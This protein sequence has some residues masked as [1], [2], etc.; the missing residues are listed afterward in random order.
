MNYPVRIL[1]LSLV[2]LSFFA[3]GNEG[4]NTRQ[5]TSAPGAGPKRFELLDPS[6]TG[7]TF[8][9]IVKEQSNVNY[10]T[11]NYLYI[12]GGIGVADFNQDGLTDLYFVAVTGE[13]K[14]YLNQGGFKFEDV[15]SKAGVGL[16]L[17]V[18]TGVTIVDINSD[19][20]PDIFQC[21]TGQTAAER[22]NKLFVNQRDGTFLEQA[23][24]YGLNTAYPST[25]ANFFDYDL[26]GDLDLYLINRP[27]DFS[28]NSNI[29]VKE[30]DGVVTRRNAPEDPLETDRLFR[31]EGNHFMDVSSQA[32]INNRAFSLSVNIMDFNDDGWPDVYVANDYVEPDHI[33]INQKNGKFVDE[34]NRYFRHLP[35]FSM[36]ADIADLNNDGLLDIVTLDMLPADNYRHKQN[37]TVMKYDRYTSLVG[38]NYGHQIMR[39]MMQINNGNGSF[40]EV[41]CLA[42]I[43]ATDWSWAPMIADL[44]NDGWKDIFITNGMKKDVN[45]RDFANYTL[46]SLEKA[47]VEVDDFSKLVH[48]I[49]SQKLSNYL[50]RNNGQL[51]MQDVTEAWGLDQP[52]FSNGAACVDLDNDGDLDIVVHNTDDVSFIYQNKTNE[53]SGGNYL[54]VNVKGQGS[55]T[56]GAGTK[57]RL[58]A[59]GQ[60]QVLEKQANRGFLS[61]MVQPLH[62]GIGDATKVERLEVIWPD[63]KMLS[64]ENVPANQQLEVEYS[65]AT[66]TWTKEKQGPAPC[67]NV[68]TQSGLNYLSLENAFEDFERERLIPRKYSNRGPAVATADVNGDGLEDVFM[69]GS[70]S[71]KGKFFLQQTS[72]TFK[73]LTQPAFEQEGLR[74]DVD[75]I[76]FDA[77][78]DGAPDLYVV[79]GGTQAPTGKGFYIDRL[80]INNREGL[81]LQHLDGLPLTDES[82]SCIAA[83]DIDR[84]GDLDLAVGGN[85]KPGEFPR[86]AYS[87]LLRNDKGRFSDVTAEWSPE[88]A[89]LGI[90]N[91]IEF[92]DLNGDSK[93]EMVVA[94]EWMG[95]KVFDIAQNKLTDVSDKF[96]LDNT[97]GWWHCLRVADF[98]GDGH[99]DIVVGNLGLNCRLTASPEQ[100]LEI[101]ATDID[102]NGQLDPILTYFN[103]GN[104]HP[105]VHRD[106]LIAQVP[107]LKKIFNRYSP[108]SKAGLDDILTEDQRKQAIHLKAG[109]LANS[110]FWG[111]ASGIFTRQD[112]PDL[113]Q[114]APIMDMAL[115]DLNGDG[116]FDIVA[117]GNDFGLEIESGRLDA[118]DGWVIFGSKDGKLEVV[119]NRLTGFWASNEG[120]KVRTLQHGATG[121]TFIV[122]GNNSNL[123]EV[124]EWQRQLQ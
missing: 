42:G 84:D 48:L 122:V 99:K 28:T 51:Q 17:G 41:A 40:N 33:Y 23:S 63:G 61:S 39:N 18:K 71:Q 108:Y 19:G 22:G 50:F 70:F 43:S 34:W 100:P 46:D 95:I 2:T 105:V 113:A 111:S 64:V 72:G 3:C 1:L 115:Q 104:R 92:A 47:G 119:P 36:G 85:V 25:E 31:N 27:E 24:A 6:Q 90:V 13:N 89:N 35:H 32:G 68:T 53:L 97:E 4:T 12:G 107:A 20:W 59:N 54:K 67:R 57:V 56:T 15:T 45:D 103:Q 81:F 75:A 98:N 38:Y 80:F 52:T 117:V 62:F 8:K 60:T 7:V 82:T 106:A 123:A 94:G 93:P 77:N 116:L 65:Q 87:Y 78:G 44:D 86:A 121:N 21:R 112:L 9:N 114:T 101:F 16:D 11:A 66:A 102:E 30:I 29:L 10:F 96:G 5:E 37:G 124:Y 88:F 55:N 76:F 58:T 110:V 73:E 49:P 120:R 83:F 91:A 74:E 14:M 109:V 69:G 79:S 26:D 118:G